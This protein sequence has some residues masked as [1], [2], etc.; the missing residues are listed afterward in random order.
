M[1]PQARTNWRSGVKL[2][3][4]VGDIDMGRKL[5]A[6]PVVTVNPVTACRCILGI[7]RGEFYWRIAIIAP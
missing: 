5:A 7:I 1:M 4:E 2:A 6:P 3:A